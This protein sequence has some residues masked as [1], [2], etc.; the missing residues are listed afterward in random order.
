MKK[1]IYLDHH[2]TTPV[3][4]RVLEVM[5]PYFSEKFGNASSR[6]HIFGDE[7]NEAVTTAR[8][9]V[10]SLIGAQKEEVIFT[11]GATESNNLA[12]KGL[13]NL[14]PNK[15]GIV[16]VATE[17]KAVLDVCT[18]LGKQ[19]I[20]I[21]ILPVTRDG[22]VSPDAVLEAITPTTVGIS[23]MAANNEIG[24]INPIEEIG[25]ICK[26]N[27]VFFHCDAAQAAGKIPIDVDKMNIDLLS[28]SGHKMYGPKGV[29]ALFVRG[30]RPRIR[31]RAQID[32]GGHEK[33]MR[34]GTLN[35]PGIVGLGKACEIAKKEMKE[36]G[37][38]LTE[39]RDYL[40][41]YLQENILDI[42]VNGG[43]EDRLPGN[44][45]VIVKGIDSEALLFKLKQE[46][47]AL[48]SGA[49]CSTNKIEPSHVLQAIGVSN[50]DLYSALRFGLGK[51]SSKK[52]IEHIFPILKILVSSL[53]S[54]RHY[55]SKKN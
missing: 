13:A 25:K 17:H 10:A 9:Q 44:L 20:E 14:N 38:R 26:E 4:P 21:T 12:L 39:L 2:A 8:G 16:T 28:L 30:H 45:S 52:E 49:A 1:S 18:S 51:N 40:L 33:G 23:V 55:I 5:L 11:S 48:S 3:D 15:K 42:K 50:D 54:I 43:M 22:R 24:A 19:G 47:I 53:R 32:G 7:A 35:V 34:S 27:E 46:G 41:K 29:G 37:K 36:E 6:H 31:L